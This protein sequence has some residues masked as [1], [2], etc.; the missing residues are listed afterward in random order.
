MCGVWCVCVCVILFLSFPNSARNYHAV[1]ECVASA[2]GCVCVRDFSPSPSPSPSHT[3][4]IDHTLS[5]SELSSP[6]STLPSLSAFGEGEEESANGERIPESTRSHVCLCLRA[7]AL[8][9]MSVHV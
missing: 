9:C 4:Q 1:R 3:Q 6:A 5:T 2:H 8:A 7:R